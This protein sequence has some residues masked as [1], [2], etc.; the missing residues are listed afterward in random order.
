MEGV[1][2]PLFQEKLQKFIEVSDTD[3]KIDGIVDISQAGDS[4][5]LAKYGVYL[6]N[7]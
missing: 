1:L 6:I 3:I 4:I 7:Y 5:I 2:V